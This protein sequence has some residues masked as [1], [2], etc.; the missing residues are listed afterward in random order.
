MINHIKKIELLELS[1][2]PTY[3]VMTNNNHIFNKFVSILRP[4][5]IIYEGAYGLRLAKSEYKKLPIGIALYGYGQQ[6][7]IW[8]LK[9]ALQKGSR[10]V[11]KLGFGINFGEENYPVVAQSAFCFNNH[12]ERVTLPIADFNLLS[13]M[14]WLLSSSELE[15]GVETVISYGGPIEVIEDKE[16]LDIRKKYSIKVIDDDTAYIYDFSNRWRIKAVSV[17]L[18]Y[19]WSES[20]MEIGAWFNYEPSKEESENVSSIAKMILDL[21]IEHN[22]RCVAKK[23]K[24][25]KE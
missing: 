17:V 6:N 11:A 13:I 15:Y 1:E 21:F 24:S 2:F 9:E 25:D 10:V 19:I 8:F 12:R 18:P 16:I 7:A 23:K 4:S 20:L 5:I 3:L 14:D 22:N